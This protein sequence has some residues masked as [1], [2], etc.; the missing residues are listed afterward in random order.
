MPSDEQTALLRTKLH[1]PRPRRGA[2]GRDRLVE[3]LDGAPRRP[4]TLISAPAGFGKTSLVAEWLHQADIPACW[5]TLDRE[6][7]DPVR[8]WTYVVEALRTL[9]PDLGQT[10][11]ELLGSE[12]RNP[13]TMIAG[14]LINDAAIWDRPLI[15]VIDDMHYIESPSLNEAI[16][17]LVENAPPNLHLVITSRADPPWPLARLRADGKVVELRANDLRLDEEETARLLEGVG[18]ELSEEGV[19]TLAAKTEGWV[20]GVQLAALSLQGR[21]HPQAFIEEL[22]GSHRF[23]LDYLTEEVLARQRPESVTFLER[24]SILGRLT[25]PLCD[26]VT[27]EPGSEA[28]LRRLEQDNVFVE[29]LDDERIWYRYHPLL[30]DVLVARLR[31][32]EADAIPA[33]HRRAAGWFEAHGLMDEAVQHALDAGDIERAARLISGVASATFAVGSQTRLLGWL[34]RLPATVIGREPTLALAHAW[35][36]FVIGDME[37][38]EDTL[39]I[40]AEAISSSLSAAQ[41][42]GMEAQLDAMR[43]WIAYQQGDVD[44]CIEFARSALDRLPADGLVPSRIVTAALGAAFLLRGDLE[45]A[46]D[47]LEQTRI[48]SH[49]SGDH[50][51]ESLAL[52]LTGEAQL[53]RDRFDGAK[54]ACRRAIDVGTVASEPLPPVGIAQVLLG[55][56]LRASGEMSEAETS[57]ISGIAI[58]ERALGLP[59]WVYEG[60]VTLAR[61]VL[62]NG[63]REH[64]ATLIEQADATYGSEIVPGHMQ[65]LVRRALAYRDRYSLSAGERRDDAVERSDLIE[66]LNERERTLLSLIAVG[67]TNQEIADELYLSVNTVKWHARNLYGKLGVS[68]RTQAVERARQLGLL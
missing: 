56:A 62:A 35:A 20:A 23:I 61:V 43:A 39:A 41:R 57:L 60:R 16:R 3:R 27:G 50:L 31:T 17:F 68:R 65:P 53:L 14:A 37:G 1:I 42:P 11:L 58:C 6:D 24:T 40:A 52:A 9:A 45:G 19:R 51:T 44:G 48:A 54:E 55:E 25:G 30:T 21:A 66:P 49:R 13:T 36:Q 63:D 38:I 18:L 67:S 15:C 29:S 4:L 32:R 7:D 33:L 10:T 12:P 64:A 2:L 59:E 8:F 28:R 47:A 46:E 22:A 5:L 26:A 34:D